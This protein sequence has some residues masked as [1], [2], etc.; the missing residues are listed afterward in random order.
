MEN[1]Y[2]EWA[3]KSDVSY[4]PKV[5]NT[6]NKERRKDFKEYKLK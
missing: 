1:A 3:S 2:F 5:W 6:Y 4:F